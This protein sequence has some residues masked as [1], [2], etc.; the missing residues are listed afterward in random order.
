MP[1][2][3]YFARL[4]S[5]VTVVKEAHAV[6]NNFIFITVDWDRNALRDFMQVITRNLLRVGCFLDMDR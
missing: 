3:M 2:K 4:V 5:F 1:T 6:H